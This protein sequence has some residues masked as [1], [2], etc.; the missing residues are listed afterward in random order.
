VKDHSP[1]PILRFLQGAACIVIIIWGIRAASTI[2]GPLLLG[3]LLA[4]AVVPFPKLLMRRFKVSKSAAIALMAVAVV[5]S[6]LYL[7]FALDLATVRISEKLPSYEQHSA[8]LYEQVTVFMNARGIV[9]P[10]LSAKNVFTPE[11]LREITRVV[12]PEAG[13]IISNGL[14]ITL[15][16][17]L[18]VVAMVEDIGVK[19]GPLAESLAYYASD[20][21]SY[22][23][24]TAK[25]AGIN[26]LVNLAFLLVMG[27]DTPV[28][29]AFLYFF[30]D[31]IPT[32][33]FMIALVPPTFVTLL[34]YGWHRALLVACGLILTNVIVDN[35]VTP[36]FMKQAVDV[37]FLEITLSLVGW[38]FLL[39][40]TGA[41][42]A[43]P[44]TLALKK[45]IAKSLQEEFLAIEP[46]G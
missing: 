44:L 31:F 35:V 5:T 15:L 45:F 19:Q 26:A 41:I 29:W 33:G 9:A 27:V 28:V 34:M 20:S 8:S 7:V 12:V 42:L 40:L 30:L 10:S 1:S 46:S 6:A 14:L 18:F 24:V 3:L 2:L 32:L 11:R 43:I 38:A 21:R 4:Y 17:F 16:A 25:T 39:G 36:I 23:A 37:S 22:V 13:V